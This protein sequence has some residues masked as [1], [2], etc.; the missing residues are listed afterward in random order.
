MATVKSFSILICLNAIYEMINMALSWISSSKLAE[1]LNNWTMIRKQF[2]LTFPEE[3]IQEQENTE[4]KKHLQT[5]QG[6]R[7][8]MLRFDIALCFYV[9]LMGLVPIFIL[10]NFMGVNSPNIQKWLLYS[11]ALHTVITEALEDVKNFLMYK[12]CS[13]AFKTVSLYFNDGRFL[14][15]NLGSVL[16]SEFIILG[17]DKHISGYSIG[18]NK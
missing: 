6:T 16:A 1:Y 13:D 4:F 10:P 7:R 18:T 15:A 12:S 5:D 8:G 14:V 2:A 9:L 11:Y 17:K 3:D